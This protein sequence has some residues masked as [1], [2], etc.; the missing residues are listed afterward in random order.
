[1]ADNDRCLF[2]DHA[3]DGQ[4]KLFCTTCLPPYG[5]WAIKAEYQRR[6]M[7]LH[8]A[9]GRNN[10]GVERC[11]I[12]KGHPAYQA[13]LAVILCRDCGTSISSGRYCR[14]CATARRSAGARKRW[15]ARHATWQLEGL[16]A[17]MSGTATD[18]YSDQ[19]NKRRR[20]AAR[21]ARA[22]RSSDRPTITRLAERD[23]WKC[24]LCGKRVDPTLTGTTNK[25][26]ASVD[27]LIP[28]SHGGVDDMV[29]A[30][31]AHLRCNAKRGNR[32]DVQLMLVA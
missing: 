13:A 1:M 18:R 6:Y 26:K 29:N 10:T 19:P 20:V 16:F 30:K 14:P 3:R 7:I 21:R 31:L 24:H 17:L 9:I 11:R 22:L 2:C 32:G 4:S 23:G 15:A 28:I 25:M 27:H 8:S 5:Q 12:R